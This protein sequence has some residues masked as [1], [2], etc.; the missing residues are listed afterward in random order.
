MH[1]HSVSICKYSGWA[2]LLL[3]QAVAWGAESQTP[4]I[5][6]ATESLSTQPSQ[7]TIR[8]LNFGGVKPWVKLDGLPLNVLLYTTTTIVAQVPQAVDASPGTYLLTVSRGDSGPIDDKEH[9]GE[10][11]LTIGAVGPSGPAGPPGPTGAQGP[12]GQAGLQGQTGAAGPAGPKGP[13][14]P[15]GESV[16]AYTNSKAEIGIGTQDTVVASVHV[17]PGRYIFIGTAEAQTFNSALTTH[18]VCGIVPSDANKAVVSLGPGAFSAASLA[19]HSLEFFLPPVSSP[20]PQLT[21][22]FKCRAFTDFG[23]ASATIVNPRLTAIK[24]DLT[25]IQ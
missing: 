24:I 5:L 9:R 15:A 18:V 11:T 8:G 21:I 23:G 7:L 17:P 12:Q 19:V 13:A 22:Y 10:F 14:G 6:S 16:W 2:A 20:P 25:S 4:I 1:K 3:W